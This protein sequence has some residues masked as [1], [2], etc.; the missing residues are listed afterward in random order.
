MDA[1]VTQM[2]EAA[3]QWDEEFYESYVS[4]LRKAYNEMGR[5]FPEPAGSWRGLGLSVANRTTDSGADFPIYRAQSEGAIDAP[6]TGMN[7]PGMTKIATDTSTGAVPFPQRN[8]K[9]LAGNS[10]N[11]KPAD[12]HFGSGSLMK[13]ATVT[14]SSTNAEGT[15]LISRLVP[16][17]LLGLGDQQN[18]QNMPFNNFLYSVTDIRVV[19]QVNGT[20]T[21]A[22]MCIAYH[23]PLLNFVPDRSSKPS[24]NHTWLTPHQNTTSELK[25]NFRYWRSA[26]NATNAAYFQ[27]V[28]GCVKV[29]VYSPLVSLS[30]S[31][32]DITMY[33]AFD[34]DFKVPRPIPI[35]PTNG[36][37]P[38]FG[39]SKNSDGTL[40]AASGTYVGQGS[41]VST[42]NVN[43]TYTVGDVGGDMPIQAG[44]DGGGKL[45]QDGK[46]DLSVPMD[47]P[48][49]AGGAI[50]VV[51]QFSSMSKSNGVEI[52]TALQL[53]QQEM[54]YQA[55]HFHDPLDTSI[56]EM[57]GKLGYL[58]K[59]S[60]STTD[61]A[62]ANK[63]V[64]KLDS[65]FDYLGQTSGGALPYWNSINQLP[66][67]VA[68]L[69]Q[70]NFWRGDI[71]FDVCVVKTPF[72][73]G[74]LLASVC[75][76]N[77]TINTAELNVYMNH[78]LD[79]N[80]D[81]AW[82]S[83]RI[84]YN[85]SQEFLRTNNG[86]GVARSRDQSVG[87]VGFTVLNELRAT[88]E[89]VSSSVEV[90]IFV[91][92][93]NVRVSVPK[94]NPRVQFGSDATVYHAQGQ[95][96]LEVQADEQDDGPTEVVNTTATTAVPPKNR[97][98]K[99]TFGEK[100]DYCVADAHELVRRH[101][102]L[103][104]KG[105][106]RTGGSITY[107]APWY[108]DK[109][110]IKDMVATTAT[111]YDVYRIAVQPISDWNRVYAGWS[112]HMK[113]RIFVYGSTPGLIWYTPQD[114]SPS[115]ETKDDFA[116][117]VLGSADSYY[118]VSGNDTGTERLAAPYYMPN[119]AR[120]MTYPYTSNC[121]MLDVSV[122]FCTQYNFLPLQERGDTLPDGIANWGNGYLYIRVAKDTR[123]EV[124]HAAG[125]DFR[126]HVFCPRNGIRSR[127]LDK[128]GTTSYTFSAGDR[129]A[130]LY[131]G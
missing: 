17:G 61:L 46:A 105:T 69:N 127:V 79:F 16:F 114:Y 54:S 71:V 22:G 34:A 32:C 84:N 118:L 44:V 15:S 68:V 52:T 86:R 95:N 78:V 66:V 128:Y 119:V 110:Q 51:G 94:P 6:K 43:N 56:S 10:L 30:A 74:R 1:E 2:I 115:F 14:W 67:N 12:L 102:P 121:S 92:F 99:L 103:S 122:P 62:V 57:C 65:T 85:N 120:E 75:Y 18:L 109:Y 40:N 3:S 26:L 96:V 55:V 20:P 31:T 129:I 25:I 33:V 82:N 126:Y 104:L 107:T 80:G 24:Y 77:D 108:L 93:E 63:L 29:D 100:F 60:W 70:F 45:T 47:N 87:C 112:G 41:N 98:C 36:A 28:L 53:H 9:E 106:I 37:L 64:L 101:I 58:T 42:T 48:P 35:A 97:A 117:L 116:D 123:I 7:L 23:V 38:S 11:E 8:M 4:A 88:S 124:F 49:V 111:Y 21:Q 131:A 39:F 50:P 130:G 5:K 19:F 90:L 89:V 13:R 76:G 113:Y 59:F 91:R 73:S 83:F 72:H 81:V 27:E 125:D